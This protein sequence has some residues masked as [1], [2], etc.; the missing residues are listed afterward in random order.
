MG[1]DLKETSPPSYIIRRR[2]L[3]NDMGMVARSFYL[4][5]ITRSIER[6]VREGGNMSNLRQL[7]LERLLRKPLNRSRECNII[8]NV[9]NFRSK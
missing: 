8:G 1:V 3:A 7:L 4:G 2:Y 6:P 9:Q 5:A